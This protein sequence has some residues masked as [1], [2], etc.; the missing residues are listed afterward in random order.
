MRKNLKEARRRAGLR[1]R[2]MA[3][4]LE[5][6]LRTYQ[7]IEAGETPVSIR[8]WDALEDLFWI[9]QRQLRQMESP[10]KK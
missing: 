2:E 9:P 5:I 6:D 4:H 10:A 3:E 1:Q 7:R 8:V